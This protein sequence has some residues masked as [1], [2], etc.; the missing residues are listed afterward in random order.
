MG[1][2]PLE[3]W[4]DADQL[5]LLNLKYDAMPADFVSVVVT[6][7]GLIPPTSVAVIL[8]E[9]RQDVVV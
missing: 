4:R 9:S 1:K 5:G 3:G 7:A 2:S 6:E 8:R